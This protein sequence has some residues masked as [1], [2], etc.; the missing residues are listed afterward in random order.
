MRISG[1]EKRQWDGD[2]DVYFQKSAWADTAFCVDWAKKTLADAMQE[3]DHF[4]LLCDN[5]SSQV[6]PE[7]Q[8]AVEE[9]GGICWFGP[10]NATD[11]WQPVDAGFG[12]LVKTLTRQ[13]FFHWLECDENSARWYGSGA[14]FT[15]SHKRIL[16][17]KWVGAAFRKL[18]SAKYDAYR[19][20]MFEKTGCLLTV[21]GS[22][23]QR[24]AP[25]GLPNYCCP[26]P[27]SLPASDNV[28]ESNKNGSEAVDAKV[29]D[30]NDIND[31]EEMEEVDLFEA[32]EQI[33]D[34][35][36]FDFFDL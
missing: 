12:M 24:V 20:R 7:F 13:A 3:E 15:A 27:T 25:E 10:P 1:E 34:G 8:T 36:V 16:I 4:V 33:E 2:V 22:E 23:D 17:T 5:L 11:I 30:T 18:T 6:S 28:P 14:S 32:S 31:F 19:R 9:I 21:D 35:N 29:D 26:A